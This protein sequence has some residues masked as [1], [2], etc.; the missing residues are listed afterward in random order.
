VLKARGFVT[1]RTV[2]A[3]S[4]DPVT[5]PKM[6]WF[7]TDGDTMPPDRTS[8]EV[9]LRHRVEQTV[10]SVPLSAL[11][12]GLR[13]CISKQILPLYEA[14]SRTACPCFPAART[15]SCPAKA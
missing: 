15:A 9:I 7:D 14:R 1:G 12:Q 11:R 6:A 5:R 2:D 4:L 3:T 10:A 13:S 8:G